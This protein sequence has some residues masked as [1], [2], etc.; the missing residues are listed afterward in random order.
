[1]PA[2]RD[3]SMPAGRQPQ[4]VLFFQNKA[5]LTHDAGLFRWGFNGVNKASG[6]KE[7]DAGRGKEGFWFRV[8]GF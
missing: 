7:L 3:I 5:I 2:L 1:M 8:S 6:A 4:K